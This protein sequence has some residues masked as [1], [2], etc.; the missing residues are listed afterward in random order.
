VWEQVSAGALAADD[1]ES[2]DVT[3]P[4]AEM[5]AGLRPRTSS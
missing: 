3:M 5:V 4:V 2:V 1:P